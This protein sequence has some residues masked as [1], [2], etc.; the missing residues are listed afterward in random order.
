MDYETA[1]DAAH[2]IRFGIDELQESIE[3]DLERVTDAI[4]QITELFKRD[5]WREIYEDHAAQSHE[6]QEYICR[7][8]LLYCEQQKVVKA[9]WSLY[10]KGFENFDESH[11][12]VYIESRYSNAIRMTVTAVPVKL[13]A[14]AQKTAP[15]LADYLKD[16]ANETV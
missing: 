5:S 14:Y 6:G 15:L 11:T 12:G 8:K 2:K 1:M 9:S 10:V 7:V 3:G 4:T 13:A 16:E